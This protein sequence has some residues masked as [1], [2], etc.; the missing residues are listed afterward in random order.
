[1][2]R[3][4]KS[5]NEH[6]VAYARHTPYYELIEKENSL[7]RAHKLFNK[8]NSVWDHLYLL[9]VIDYGTLQRNYK[10]GSG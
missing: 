5:H 6:A 2:P 7:H 9:D 3:L 4:W 10:C 8:I 1:M